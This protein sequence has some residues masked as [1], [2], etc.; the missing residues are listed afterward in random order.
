VAYAVY[1]YFNFFSLLLL[2]FIFFQLGRKMADDETPGATVD[3]ETEMQV[4][5]WN[6]F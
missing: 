1:Q 4:Q 2:A 3:R 6:Q 5:M